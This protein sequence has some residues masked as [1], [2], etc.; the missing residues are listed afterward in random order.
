[1]RKEAVKRA[2]EEETILKKLQ[3]DKDFARTIARE[4]LDSREEKAKAEAERADAEY[5]AKM[6]SISGV[7]YRYMRADP[8]DGRWAPTSQ[9]TVQQA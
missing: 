4:L 6:D 2:E 3:V 5:E 9:C 8:F 7:N 1:L